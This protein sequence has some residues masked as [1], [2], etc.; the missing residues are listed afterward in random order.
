MRLIICNTE[1]RHYLA[2]DRNLNATEKRSIYLPPFHYVV[3][4]YICSFP[5]KSISIYVAHP[6]LF[7]KQKSLSFLSTRQSRSH[8]CR[9]CGGTFLKTFALRSATPLTP[10]FSYPDLRASFTGSLVSRNITR[11]EGPGQVRSP[12]RTLR[13]LSSYVVFRK[14]W[15]VSGRAYTP[16]LNLERPEVKRRTPF[17][18]IILDV[19]RTRI[20]KS[21]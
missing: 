17:T 21:E 12:E 15:N 18:P 8:L 13:D 3:L 2:F 19:R 10:P 1:K 4:S 20:L 11:L 5:H 6:P 16:L 7:I 9:S 14:T